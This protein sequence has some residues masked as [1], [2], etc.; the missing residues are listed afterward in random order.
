MR[1]GNGQGG[2]AGVGGGDGVGPGPGGVDV[3]DAAPCAADKASGDGEDPQAQ[4]F[5]LVGCGRGGEGEAGAPGQ[6]VL[7]QGG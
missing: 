1:S 7:G 6:Q 5:G 4:P 2:Q 3:Q